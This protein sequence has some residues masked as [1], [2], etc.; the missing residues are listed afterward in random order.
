MSLI[1]S[2]TDVLA[3]SLQIAYATASAH[4]TVS[5]SLTEAAP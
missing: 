5:A 4:P 3:A 1:R 2:V